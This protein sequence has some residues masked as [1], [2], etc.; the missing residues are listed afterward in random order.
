[1]YGNY[2]VPFSL[3]VPDDLLYK[4]KFTAKVHSRSANKE[5]EFIL[6]Q[7]IA[8]FERKFGPIDLPVDLLESDDSANQ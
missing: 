4:V 2:Y 5:M 3:R 6:K 7:Y 8:Q 1:M